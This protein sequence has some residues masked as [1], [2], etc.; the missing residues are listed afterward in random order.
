M[1]ISAQPSSFDRT[2]LVAFTVSG[3]KAQDSVK[4]CILLDKAK[5]DGD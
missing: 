3:S 5:A 4:R 1:F 2:T